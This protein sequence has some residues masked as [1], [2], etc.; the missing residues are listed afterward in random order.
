[1]RNRLWRTCFGAVALCMPVLVFLSGCD[2]P[3]TLQIG[4][5][6]PPFSMREIGGRTVDLEQYR[7]KVVVLYF[8]AS[9]CLDTL[10]LIEPYYEQHRQEIEV[11][12]VNDNDAAATAAYARSNKITFT[13]LADKPMKLFN[14]YKAKGFPT[15]YIV[16]RS[17]VI[18]EKIIGD[19]GLEPLEK[20]M[21]RQIGVG[22]KAAESYEKMLGR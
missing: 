22:K 9:C 21:T 17:G 1:M 12:A 8:W 3:Q 18:R 6:A 16:D 7:G 5:T 19:I 10:K 2:S 20:L 14:A 15:I 11:I 13:M 4:D